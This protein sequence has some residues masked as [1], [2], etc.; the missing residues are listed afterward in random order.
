MVY[1]IGAGVA[2]EQRVHRL[3]TRAEPAARR[4]LPLRLSLSLAPRGVSEEG[5]HE[6]VSQGGGGVCQGGVEGG[7][8][9]A[10]W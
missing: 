8:L 3:L 10:L 1:L 2:V 5:A 7:A 9:G 6:N 4:C